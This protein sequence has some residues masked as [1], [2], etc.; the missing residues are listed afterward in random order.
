MKQASK[1]LILVFFLSIQAQAK[2]SD[3]DQPLHIQAGSVEIREQDGIS[4]YKDNVLITRGTMNIQGELIYV[5]SNENEIR[6]I[7]VEGAPAKFRQLND[8]DAEISAQ[9]LQMEYQANN[10]KLILTKDAVLVQGQNRFTSEHIIYDTQQDIV[11]A[12]DPAKKGEATESERVTITIQPDKK[13][14]SE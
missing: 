10:N 12:G 11:Q 4:I 2:T 8:Q 7:R 3:M 6:T 13:K 5:H 9:S 1:L 14:N